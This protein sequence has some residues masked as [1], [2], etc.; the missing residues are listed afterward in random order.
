MV[1]YGI[2]TTPMLRDEVFSCFILTASGLS[3]T[4]VLIGR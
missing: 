2:L 3:S 4:T 1:V